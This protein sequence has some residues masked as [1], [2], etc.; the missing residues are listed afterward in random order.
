MRP[1][2]TIVRPIVGGL[3]VIGVV[4]TLGGHVTNPMVLGAI[5]VTTASVVTESLALLH[6]RVARH[7]A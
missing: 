1:P 7:R 4:T 3:V 2:S 5:A 6:G